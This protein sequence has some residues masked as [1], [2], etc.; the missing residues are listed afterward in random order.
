MAKGSRSRSAYAELKLNNQIMTIFKKINRNILFLSIAIVFPFLECCAQTDDQTNGAY[1][2]MHLNKAWENA[3]INK[4]GHLTESEDKRKWR[5]WKKLD[6]NKDGQVSFEEFSKKQIP[7]L[8]TGGK[9]K[10]NVLYKVC[11]L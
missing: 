2:E 9:R 3:D 1:R 8:N 4:D 7:Y 6:K 11:L 10:L 5:R